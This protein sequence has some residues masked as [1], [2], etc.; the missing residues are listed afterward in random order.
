MAG[1]NDKGS[2]GPVEEPKGLQ[3]EAQLLQELAEIPA[4]SAAWVAPSNHG[5]SITVRALCQTL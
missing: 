5:N 3:S 2:Q 4:I 1:D